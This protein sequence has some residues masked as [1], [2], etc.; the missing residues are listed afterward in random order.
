MLVSIDDFEA[1]EETLEILA[2][3]QLLT[4]IRRSLS[5]TKRYTLEQARAGLRK[6]SKA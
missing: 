1:L 4:D 3:R 6:R 5:S 2:D